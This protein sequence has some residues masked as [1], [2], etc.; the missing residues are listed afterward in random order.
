MF[1][2]IATVFRVRVGLCECAQSGLRKSRH[3]QVAVFAV[4]IRR[5]LNDDFIMA[6]RCRVQNDP[7]C[8]QILLLYEL[9]FVNDTLPA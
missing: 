7:L 6:D 3:L 2:E 9:Y 4:T 1:A 8:V 5:R